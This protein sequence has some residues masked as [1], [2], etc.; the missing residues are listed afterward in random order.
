MSE[1]YNRIFCDTNVGNLLNKELIVRQI[2]I[3]QI[4]RAES[5]GHQC[6]YKRRSDK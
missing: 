6:G 1:Q 2:I 3:S 4:E 5:I